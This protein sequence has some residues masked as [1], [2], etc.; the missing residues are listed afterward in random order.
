MRS[1]VEGFLQSPKNPS[2]ELRAVPLPAKT[3]GGI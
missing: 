3:R 2:T 1:M